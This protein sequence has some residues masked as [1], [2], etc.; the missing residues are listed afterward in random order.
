MKKEEFLEILRDYLEKDFSIAEIEDI[1]R[2][3]EEY[4]ID[5]AIEGK[6][7]HDIILSLGSPK[8]I[9][10]ELIE[11]N[12]NKA[13]E[14]SSKRES[15]LEGIKKHLVKI[16]NRFKINLHSDNY[17]QTRRKVKLYQVLVL[18]ALIP[19]ASIAGI[20]TLS[21]GLGLIGSLFTGIIGVP[22]ASSLASIMPEVKALIIFGAIAFIGFEIL[23][24][25]LY[26]FIF[27]KEVKLFKKYINWFK[28]NQLYINKSSKREKIDTEINDS[29]SLEEGC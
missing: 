13:E 10:K 28:R 20:T 29:K 22:F 17:V 19:V 3:Y 14:K 9:A 1:L 6:T 15:V 2:D 5:G 7:E 4:F 27:K 24:W 26:V 25:Q 16:K 11:E 18:L 23:A 12:K 8:S 21:V